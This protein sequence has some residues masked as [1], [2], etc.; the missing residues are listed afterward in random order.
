MSEEKNLEGELLILLSLLVFV[1]LVFSFS[2][3]LVFV[4]K[5]EIL[6]YTASLL[7]SGLLYYLFL[8]FYQYYLNSSNGLSP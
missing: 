2:K 8:L 1:V 5:S 3:L 6:I 4:F 7:L